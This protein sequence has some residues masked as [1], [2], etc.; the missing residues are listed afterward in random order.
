MMPT[1]TYTTITDTIMNTSMVTDT[2]I[3]MNT[4]I[5]MNTNICMDTNMDMDISIAIYMSMNTNIVMLMLTSIATCMSMNTSMTIM[6]M[7]LMVA[8]YLKFLLGTTFLMVCTEINK[9]ERINLNPL[10][11]MD[12][13]RNIS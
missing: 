5:C 9:G 6:R 4:S 1:L 10:T 3:R 11:N 8:I 2:S 12:T 13:W 7:D